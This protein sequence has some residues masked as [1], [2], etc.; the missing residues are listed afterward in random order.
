[1]PSYVFRLIA[2]FGLLPRALPLSTEHS[3]CLSAP[4][5]TRYAAKLE[6]ECVC[7]AAVPRHCDD[8]AGGSNMDRGG[9]RD[10]ATILYQGVVNGIAAPIPRRSIGPQANACVTSD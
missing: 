2:L 9:H 6:F 10:A 8:I 5:T 3:V 7:A 4:L 1:M